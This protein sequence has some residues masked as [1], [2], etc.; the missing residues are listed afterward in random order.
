MNFCV[1]CQCPGAGA[2]LGAGARELIHK[3][4]ILYVAWPWV[5]WT[6][7]ALSCPWDLCAQPSMCV[8]C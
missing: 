4:T 3:G 2:G 5:L 1:G 7:R 8:F 6:W